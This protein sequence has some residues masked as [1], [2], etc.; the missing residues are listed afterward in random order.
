[1]AILQ[2]P[3]T[4][5]HRRKAP[6]P[7]TTGPATWADVAVPVAAMLALGAAAWP[8]LWLVDTAATLLLPPVLRALGVW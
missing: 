2:T 5:R 7:D 1:M 6:L 4:M 8:L 3:P